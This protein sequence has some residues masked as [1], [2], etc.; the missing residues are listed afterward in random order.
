M[1][2]LILAILISFLTA[3]AAPTIE[4]PNN[5]FAKT[6]QAPDHAKRILILPSKVDFSELTAGR[7][8]VE[9]QIYIQLQRA[10]YQVAM[11]GE[12][13]YTEVWG[14][15]VE[16]VGGLYDSQTGRFRPEAYVR[17]LSALAR[18]IN[19]EVDCSTVLAPRFVLQRAKLSHS[20]ASWDGV[21]RVEREKGQALMSD[22]KYDYDGT[23]VGLSMELM[24]FDNNGEWQFTTYGGILLPY[25]TDVREKKNVLRSDLFSDPREIVE[26]TALVLGPLLPVKQ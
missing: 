12:K 6:F 25:Q 21:T 16:A 2:Y 3:C 9:H 13:N 18:R 22:S 23:T 14:Q 20:N 26:A 10:G 7:P 5:K 17:A 1:R 24:A 11:L 15:E 19:A 8:L 4:Q